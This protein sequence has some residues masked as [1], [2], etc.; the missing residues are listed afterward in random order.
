MQFK[1]LIL[2]S[3]LL[4]ALLHTQH[5]IAQTELPIELIELLGEIED[6]NDMLSLAMA[7]LEQKTNTAIQTSGDKASK[8]QNLE[9]A[10]PAGGSKK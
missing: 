1:S 7:E 2:G 4:M 3:M 10:A 6:D 9:I 5:V 8:K